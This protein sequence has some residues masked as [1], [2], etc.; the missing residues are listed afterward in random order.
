V[1]NNAPHQAAAQAFLTYLLSPAGAAVL[2]AQG[3]AL[4]TPP[5]VSGTVPSSLQG[6]LSGQ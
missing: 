1:L 2:K 5:T 3:L 4:T 6:V